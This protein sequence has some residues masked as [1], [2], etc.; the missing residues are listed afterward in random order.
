MARRDTSPRPVLRPEGFGA[1]EQTERMLQPEGDPVAPTEVLKTGITKEVMD[2]AQEYVSN[3]PPPKQQ[4]PVQKAIDKSLI[5]GAEEDYEVKVSKVTPEG[6]GAIEGMISRVL[7]KEF[8]GDLDAFYYCTTFVSDMLDSIG[9][10]PLDDKGDKY[11]RTRANAYMKYGTPVD[12]EDIQEGDIVIFDFPKLP[13]GTL[14]LDPTRGKRN[15]LGDH[16]TFYA[17]DRLDVNKPGSNYIGVLGGE[18]GSGAAIS[19]KAFDKSHILGIRRIQYNDIDYEFTKELAKVNPDFN[20]FLNNEAKAF[21]FNAFMEQSSNLIQGTNRLTSGFDEGGLTKSK[22]LSWGEL[23]VDNI[24]GLDNEYESFGEK[25]GKAINEDEIKFLKDAAV[26]VYEGTK[27]FVQAPVETT[28]Q[29]VNEIKDSVTRLGSEDLNTRLQRMYGVSYEQATDEQV[30]QAREAVLGD[31][32]TALELVPAAKVTT[33]VAS[34]AIPSG[35]KADAI[36]QTKALLSGDREFLSATPTNRATTQSLSAGFTGQNPPTY[37]F[38]EEPPFDPDGIYG[39]KEGILKFR[40]P[41]AEFTLNLTRTNSFPSK[42]I[43]GA[44]FLRLL[45][46]NAESIPPSSYKEGLVDKDK[47]YTREELL[48]AVTKSP[49]GLPE[50]IY[51]N[52]A[53][54]EA[55][56]NFRGYQRQTQVGFTGYPRYP[57]DTSYFSIPILSRTSGNTFKANSQHFDASTTAHVRG[58]FIDPLVGFEVN[59][60]L[61]PEFKSIVGKDRPYLLVEEIQSDLLQKGYR[62]PKNSFDTAFNRAADET[63]AG[64]PVTFQE[65]YGDLTNE[66]KSLVKS[67]ES[68]G[69]AMPEEPVRLQLPYRTGVLNHPQFKDRRRRDFIDELYSPER[70][71]V[72]DVRLV[73]FEEIK[74]YI[75]KQGVNSSHIHQVLNDIKDGA[76]RTRSISDFESVAFVG[77]NNKAYDDIIVRSKDPLSENPMYIIDTESAAYGEFLKDFDEYTKKFGLNYDDLADAYDKELDKYYDVIDKE[78]TDRKLD[79]DAVDGAFVNGLYERFLEIKK[80]QRLLGDET[81]TALP[82][83][84]KNKQTVEEALKLLIAKADQEGVDKIVIPPASKIAEARGRTIDPSDKGDR[85]YRTYVADLNKALEDLEKNYPVTVHRD[86]DLPYKTENQPTRTAAEQ[87]LIDMGFEDMVND[88]PNAVAANAADDAAINDGD[89]FTVEEGDQFF[90]LPEGFFDDVPDQDAPVQQPKTKAEPVNHKGTIID[91]SKLREQFQVDKPRQFAEGGTVDMNQQ[92]SFAFEDGGLRDDG[93]MR[94]PVSGNEVPPGS[95]AKEVRDDIPAQLSEGEYVVP[96][97][98]V[99]YYG[100]KF[101]E[102]LR[103]NAKMGLQDMEARGRI[104]G[105]PVPAGGP[106]DGDDLSPEEMAAIQEMMGMAEGGVVNMY[107]QQQDL[108]SDPNPAIG[109]SMGMASGGQVRGFNPGGLQPAAQ[110]TQDQIYAAGQ[111]AQQAA[112]V[113]APLGFSI[114]PTQ[115]QLD[116][117]QTTPSYAT[118]QQPAFEPVNLIHPETF[119]KVVATTQEMYD[120]YL[121]QGYVLDDGSIAPAGTQTAPDDGG[122][123]PPPTG[124]SKPAY[125]DW[126]NSAD[127]NSEAGIE[128]F[129]ASIEYDPSKSNLDMQTLGATVLAGPMAGLATAAGGALRGGGLQAISDMRAASLIAKAQ[130]LDE[131]AGKIDAQVAD[132]IKDGPDILDFLDDVFATGKQKANAFAKKN[133]YSSIDDMLKVPT[134]RQAQIKTAATTPKFDPTKPKPKPSTYDDGKP[135]FAGESLSDVVSAANEAAGDDGQVSSTITDAGT[136]EQKVSGG[137]QAE[138]DYLTSAAAG[139]KGGLMNKAALKKKAKRQYKKGGLAN[140]K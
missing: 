1:A 39:T 25:L 127:F 7:G 110:Q 78:I 133:G 64:S 81:N 38:K 102:D 104:G 56:P 95:T 26:G 2:K 15:G 140:K 51:Y 101:F 28:K 73:E 103:D 107:K 112:Y 114:F 57:E 69:V 27:E 105:E 67:L 88:N 50:S 90:E 40:E 19:M 8:D 122:S 11:N 45:E 113:G 82:P 86:V 99:R 41:I 91:I 139:N 85:F 22:G 135:T 66:L 137:T 138:Q 76:N 96:A 44:E 36:G 21:D 106:M 60:T 94:D 54:L 98:V 47:R 5:G 53:D 74:D 46:K 115:A 83:V 89:L 116:A 120:Q 43:T 97:D 14:T 124:D 130:G 35:L 33:T 55:S 63:M 10:D 37:L 20:K 128:K 29:V 16:A 9:A 125:E 68:K 117:G 70:G 100:V 132:I 62:K 75:D 3:P 93:M 65:V 92:M 17:G 71:T 52:L 30:N 80:D 59:K 42:G 129:V 4:S 24:L 126:L 134:A 79:K 84:R 121:E 119:V 111:Q 48:D 32:L 108:Y 49:A 61:S 87:H 109:N 77:P 34:A 58:S 118:A 131:L 72:E 12:I 123:T 23:I 18:Q 6:R 31:A 136:A 13:D